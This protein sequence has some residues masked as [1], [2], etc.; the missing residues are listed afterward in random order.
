MKRENFIQITNQNYISSS[1]LSTVSQLGK[2][3]IDLL[4]KIGKRKKSP[5]PFSTRTMTWYVFKILKKNSKKFR[6]IFFYL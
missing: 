6:T 3:S 2:I 1:A 4:F 5:R